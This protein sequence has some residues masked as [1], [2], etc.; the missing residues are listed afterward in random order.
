MIVGF[1][2]SDGF[3]YASHFQGR[4]PGF[5]H[6]STPMTIIYWMDDISKDEILQVFIGNSL[7]ASMGLL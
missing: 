5:S 2:C 6:D 4:G 7:V 3:G 1:R